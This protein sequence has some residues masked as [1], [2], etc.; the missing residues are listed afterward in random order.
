MFGHRVYVFSDRRHGH[1]DIV[2]IKQQSHDLKTIF[3]VGANVGQSAIRFRAA[4]PDAR[5]Y[6][7]EPVQSTYLKL[8]RNTR[9]LGV[10]CLRVALAE[11]PGKREMYLYESSVLNTL[12]VSESATETEEAPVT[13]I[14]QFAEENK[15]KT[16]DLLKID[17]EGLDLEVLQGATRT[18]SSGV[19]SLV[20]VEAGF[21]R[22]D[23]RHVLFDDVRD[24]LCERGFSV[25][26]IYDQTLERS[27]ERRLRFA[28]VLFHRIPTYKSESHSA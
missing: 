15:I 1:R 14:D 11:T 17:T 9:G 12:V 22:G 16:I 24:F 6:S 26:G 18:I 5:I 2:D 4:F 20:I 3:D 13:T 25:Y 19:V 21:H 27:G 23:N 8:L 10:Y 28:N 7:F